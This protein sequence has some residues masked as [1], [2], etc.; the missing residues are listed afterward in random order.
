MP[1][2]DIG[3]SFYT[4]LG[5]YSLRDLGVLESHVE[6]I[7][8]SAAGNSKFKL[9]FSDFSVGWTLSAPDSSQ[10]EAAQRR[11]TK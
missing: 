3:S 11:L 9:G 10:L 6:H 4:E 8:A 2:E 1:P 7:A 5:P